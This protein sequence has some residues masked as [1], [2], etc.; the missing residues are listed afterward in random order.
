[1]LGR[2]G[3]QDRGAAADYTPPSGQMR[4]PGTQ[5]YA[6][7][8]FALAWFGLMMIPINTPGSS[9]VLLEA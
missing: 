7:A 9:S 2:A 3:A 6:F 4:S 1:M 5:G 8:S